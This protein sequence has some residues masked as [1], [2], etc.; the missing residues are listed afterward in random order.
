MKRRAI[1]TLQEIK[2]QINFPSG[3]NSLHIDSAVVIGGSIAGLTATQVL[4]QFA[5]QVTIIDRDHM[6]GQNDF[7]HGAPQGRH[8]HTLLPQGQ[9]E[10]GRLFPNFSERMVARGAVVL[11]DS[12]DKPFYRDGRWHAASKGSGRTISATR[13]LI[14]SVLFEIVSAQENVQ[15]I[16]G[17][18]VSGLATG[19]EHHR[20]TGVQLRSRPGFAV[21]IPELLPADIVIDTS[22]RR[23]KAP[24]WLEKL[25]FTPPE[26]W[27]IDSHAGYATRFFEIPDDFAETWKALYIL[28]DPQAGTRGGL[29]LPVEGNRWHVTLMGVNRDYPP[30][31]EDGFLAFA[32]SLPSQR[33][34]RAIE[35]AR[36][37]SKPN[38]YRGTSN[39]VR[40]YDML[41]RYL[42]G[43]LVMG[44]AVFSMN[45]VYA[46]GMTA[47][48]LGG[49][50]LES[51][52][53]AWSKK[54]SLQGLSRDFQR[55]LAKQIDPLWKIAVRH[56]WQWPEV[57]LFDNT[58][59]LYP[60][61]D[62]ALAAA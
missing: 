26:E 9:R 14:E 27:Q 35:H 61:L 19:F 33:L 28:L 11:D 34:F 55:R 46:Q 25:G 43:L 38:G 18:E 56:E 10:L 6:I 40:R 8:A 5:R 36:A 21:D 1:S 15:I 60:R 13:P 51:S 50:A 29:L 24:A 23:S 3:R 41:P 20:V 52:L 48:S 37:L 16:S 39:Q 59:Q 4:S 17:V 54:S 53:Q 47:V 45:P 42:E 49:R 57:D 30:L 12:Q 22:G 31:D 2:K 7:R 62:D 58:E 32:H 44:D